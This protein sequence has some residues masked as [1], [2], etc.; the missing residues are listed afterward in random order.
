MCY[1]LQ[2]VDMQT[3]KWSDYCRVSLHPP[4]VAG[5]P[6]NCLIYRIFRQKNYLVR[7]DVVVHFILWSDK[8]CWMSEMWGGKSR[9]LLVAGL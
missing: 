8:T 6:E 1:N 5:V 2:S 9:S 7:Q 4:L 3:D